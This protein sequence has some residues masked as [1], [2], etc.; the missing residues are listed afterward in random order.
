MNLNSINNLI[1]VRS[2]ILMVLISFIG[3]DSKAD[4]KKQDYIL[5]KVIND[6]INSPVLSIQSNKESFKTYKRNST[7][8]EKELVIVYNRNLQSSGGYNQ[9][10]VENQKD[11]SNFIFRFSSGY[12]TPDNGDVTSDCVISFISKSEVLEF[13]EIIEIIN[14]NPKKD[15][16]YDFKYLT[17]KS[18]LYQKDVF[19]ANIYSNCKYPSFICGD[20]VDIMRNVLQE[21]K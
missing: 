21:Y 18:K 11:D 5:Y 10:F 6:G 19:G 14:N 9:L 13:L 3:C 8:I 17:I 7:E 20:E 1:I 15:L 16:T 2:L 4:H 12:G